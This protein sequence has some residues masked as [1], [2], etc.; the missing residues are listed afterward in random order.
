MRW[1]RLPGRGWWPASAASSRATVCRL[2]AHDAS[3]LTPPD[4]AA[5]V[6]RLK[7][8]EVVPPPAVLGAMR[9]S[10]GERD[11]RSALHVYD[12]ARAS[13]SPLCVQTYNV[14]L[15]A[16][17]QGLWFSKVRSCGVTNTQ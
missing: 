3:S 7:A 2:F 11:W 16:C 1:L 15:E 17:V 13:G 10:A 4:A 9:R 12:V 6:R 5:L 8:G 14:A